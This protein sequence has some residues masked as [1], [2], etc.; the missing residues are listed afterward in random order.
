[1]HLDVAHGDRGGVA[2]VA[3][4]GRVVDQPG[5]VEVAD[6]ALDDRAGG[7]GVDAVGK[8]VAGACGVVE[9]AD[10]EVDLVRAG[11]GV[12][13]EGDRH[14]PADRAGVHGLVGE[15]VSVDL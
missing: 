1:G 9:A 6:H 7:V 8:G 14:R 15:A 2:G 13:G 11:G 5:T 3:G 10:R 12:L 4:V